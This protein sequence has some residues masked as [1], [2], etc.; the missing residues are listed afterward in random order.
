MSGRVFGCHFFR[1]GVSSNAKELFRP[2][3]SSR[4]VLRG[5]DNPESQST[6]FVD[7][8]QES[9]H[10]HFD[11]QRAAKSLPI[12]NCTVVAME[13]NIWLESLSVVKLCNGPASCRWLKSSK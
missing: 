10:E 6:L 9:W 13:V 8:V 3:G 7:L 12:L 4:L 2:S 1:Q 5:Q 11:L